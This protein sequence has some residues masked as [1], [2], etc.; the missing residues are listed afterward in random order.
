MTHLTNEELMGM[1]GGK[2]FSEAK[3]RPF[4]TEKEIADFDSLPVHEAPSEERRK[5]TGTGP[6]DWRNVPGVVTPVKD[7]GTC[8]TCWAFGATGSMEGAYA[9][10]G[11]TTINTPIRS[12]TSAFTFDPTTNFYGFSE[13]YLFECVP[14][15]T[16]AGGNTM[17][18]MAYAQQNGVMLSEKLDP[19][20][21][22]SQTSGGPANACNPTIASTGMDQKFPIDKQMNPVLTAVAPYNVTA[23]EDALR[24]GPVTIGVNA[25]TGWPNGPQPF[26][27]YKEGI[28]TLEDGCVNY[29]LD[30][31]VLLVGFNTSTITTTTQLDDGSSSSTTTTMDYWIVKNSWAEVW[32]M[33]GYIYIE[34]SDAN[35]CGVLN[36]GVYP[37]MFGALNGRVAPPAESYLNPTVSSDAY[38]YDGFG[39]ANI[40]NSPF[41][42][43]PDSIMP[44]G[45]ALEVQAATIYYKADINTTAVNTDVLCL[46]AGT[47]A[48]W[49]CFMKDEDLQVLRWVNV[50]VILWP[51]GA[52][53]TTFNAKI[54][55]FGYGT[56]N[57]T[58]PLNKIDI[59]ITLIGKI[60]T[61][62]V[63]TPLAIADGDVGLGLHNVTF[64]SNPKFPTAQPTLKPPEPP[65]L[66]PGG[67]ITSYFITKNYGQEDCSGDVLFTT[68]RTTG[69][70][71][72]PVTNDSATF[73]PPNKGYMLVPDPP[74]AV[75]YNGGYAQGF[76]LVG[77][78]TT[79]CNGTAKTLG[80]QTTNVNECIPA[81]AQVSTDVMFQGRPSVTQMVKLTDPKP[82]LPKL[83]GVASWYTSEAACVADDVTQLIQAI[84]YNSNCVKLGQYS[85]VNS[86]GS[87]KAVCNS[88][89]GI[90]MYSYTDDKCSVD[91]TQQFQDTSLWAIGTLFSVCT[92]YNIG[93]GNVWAKSCCGGGCAGDGGGSSTGDDDATAGSDDNG[94][95]KSSSTSV[96]TDSN[97][98]THVEI[99]FGILAVLLFVGV[100]VMKHLENSAVK[101]NNEA[102]AAAGLDWGGVNKT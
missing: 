3:H 66:V 6:I 80:P 32:G 51:E 30:H 50:L 89:T 1:N 95:G 79:Y 33:D 36:A 68:L 54:E 16:C 10:S 8:G 34:K 23:M 82:S 12:A 11:G 87:F 42:S 99:G 27:S 49:L 31:S 85:G 86:G 4:F 91:A 44:E 100:I 62:D 97:A 22:G 48:V 102:A 15:M 29:D 35:A 88:T 14:N 13:Q 55:V 38:T 57:F 71:N 21:A 70:C 60:S 26:Q 9:L 67:N 37:N 74:A 96:P 76:E 77:F 56:Q 28:V 81:D 41:Q 52:E 64:V 39:L 90:S 92:E 73:F 25:G 69:L 61:M 40:T 94:E 47:A 72:G 43:Y 2:F 78:P 7:Q 18:G 19:Y 83:S 65:I 58:A 101:A 98:T 5:L 63:N 53:S 17:F 24:L 93:W 45:Q 46:N 75:S 84:S 59:F 20:T